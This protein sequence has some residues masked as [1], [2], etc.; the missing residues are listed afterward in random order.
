MRCV[1]L[2]PKILS[3]SPYDVVSYC[4]LLLLKPVLRNES[5][6]AIPIA[7]NNQ[8][9]LL[10]PKRLYFYQKET[11]AKGVDLR[12]C[13]C[14]PTCLLSHRRRCKWR[15]CWAAGGLFWGRRPS[16]TSFLSE[17]GFMIACSPSFHCANWYFNIWLNWQSQISVEEAPKP[18]SQIVLCLSCAIS[19]K[20]GVACQCT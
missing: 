3:L 20:F 4:F 5:N 9:G 6:E 17:D 18:S 8:G 11:S 15:R 7:V 13:V 19:D 14:V 2:T 12:V 10:L 1:K 16:H